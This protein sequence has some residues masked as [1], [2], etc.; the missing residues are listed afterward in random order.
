MKRSIACLCLSTVLAA[1]GGSNESTQITTPTENT[2]QDSTPNDA[3][4]LNFWK[5]RLESLNQLPQAGDEEASDSA[6]APVAEADIGNDAGGVDDFSSTNIQV[7]GVDE[8]DAL[9]FDGDVLLSLNT[10]QN[11]YSQFDG[12]YPSNASQSMVRVFSEDMLDGNT[13]ENPNLHFSPSAESTY[14]GLLTYDNTAALIGETYT[15][16]WFGLN[17]PDFSVSV[18]ECFGCYPAQNASVSVDIWQYKDAQQPIAPAPAKIRIEGQLKDARSID[19]KIYVLSSYHP[20]VEGFTYYPRTQE[21]VNQNAA[22]IAALSLDDLRPNIDLDGTTAPLTREQSCILPGDLAQQ[23]SL[24]SLHILTEID[25]QNPSAI[26]TLCVIDYVQESYFGTDNIYLLSNSYHPNTDSSDRVDI[27]KIKITEDGMQ[28]AGVGQVSGSLS[29]DSYQLG[30]VDGKFAMVNTVYNYGETPFFRDVSFYHQLSILDEGDTGLELIAQIPNESRPEAIG[31]PGERI[32]AV[33]FMKQRAYVVTF[34]QIDPLY[35]IDL[36]DTADPKI[37]GE[38]E[39]PGFSDY[40]HVVSDNLLFGIGKNAENVDGLTFFEG[41]NVRLFDVSDPSQPSLLVNLDYGSRGSE[42]ALLSDPHALAYTLNPASGIAR[43]AFPVRIH[44]T[45]EQG[46]G[47]QP[48]NFYPWQES[49]LLQMEIDTQEK[50]LQEVA[51]YVYA[52]PESTGNTEGWTWYWSWGER[53]VI[54]N[55]ALYFSHNS[56]LKVLQWGANEVLRSFSQP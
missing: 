5:T 23:G 29:G 14:R 41:L 47:N 24:P 8:I 28:S 43:L 36:S 11:Y 12:S 37:A 42:S 38:L 56:E 46:E 25:M 33:R 19:N 18:S 53:S 32:Y 52:T 10:T 9:K 35:V 21:Q 49:A 55:E 39:I 7:A 45:Q 54:N 34:E 51:R 30:E 48:G 3:N 20:Q 31:K 6:P 22:I 1:C 17:K 44:G 15:D 50:T 40:I 2:K 16:F 4:L 27:R 13:E 26:E